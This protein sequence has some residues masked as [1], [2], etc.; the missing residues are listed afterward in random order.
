MLEIDNIL[1]RQML[2]SYF[3]KFTGFCGLEV[4]SIS[5]NQSTSLP[6]ERASS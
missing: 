6:L 2:I 3:I 5:R 1:E 4:E